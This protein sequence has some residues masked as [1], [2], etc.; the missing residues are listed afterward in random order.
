MASESVAISGRFWDFIGAVGDDTLFVGLGLVVSC[1]LGF[2]LAAGIYYGGGY[3][4][5]EKKMKVE[6]VIVLPLSE[7]EVGA[8][9]GVLLL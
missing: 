4:R 8:K 2:A 1:I 7:K 3:H 9:E 6:E 5:V